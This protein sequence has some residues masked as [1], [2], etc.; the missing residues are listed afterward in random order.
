MKINSIVKFFTLFLALSTLTLSVGCD[1]EDDTPNNERFVGVYQVTETCSS[2]TFA[3]QIEIVADVN[4]DNAVTIQNFGDFDLDL[5]ATV[6][7]N[8]ITLDDTIP[9]DDSLTGSGTLQSN[10]LTMSYDAMLTG[11]EDNC[12]FTGTKQ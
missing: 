9:G 7:G 11:F 12:T 1:K 5:K 10:I 6:D 2:G 4:D 8:N 3:Y